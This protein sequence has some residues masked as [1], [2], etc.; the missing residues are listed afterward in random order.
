ME[1]NFF[2]FASTIMVTLI[3]NAHEGEKKCNPL[4]LLALPFAIQT[5]IDAAS[6]EKKNPFLYFDWI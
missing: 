4:L 6:R 3:F 1:Y 2:V 5:E